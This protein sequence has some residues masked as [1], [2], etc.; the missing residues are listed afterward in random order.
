M[1]VESAG[2]RVK[3]NARFIQWAEK[4]GLARK[5]VIVLMIAA[6]GM[7]LLTYAVLSGWTP[8]GTSEKS[9]R[10]VLIFLNIDLVLFLLLGAVVARRLVKLWMERRRGADHRIGF[11]GGIL[12]PWVAI[13]V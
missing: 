1:S 7:A 12:Q 13:L 6:F 4:V 5:L 3:P 10:R 9:V 8:F 2:I 11:V